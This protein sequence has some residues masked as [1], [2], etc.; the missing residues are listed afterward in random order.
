MKAK[1]LLLAAG[2]AFF[3]NTAYGQDISGDWQGTLEIAQR[4]LLVIVK[5]A[6]VPEGWSARLYSPEG[7]IDVGVSTR[8]DSVTLQGQDLRLTVTA[9]QATYTGKLS[10]DGNSIEGTWT[11]GPPTPLSRPLPLRRATPET[12]WKDPSPHTS[13]FVTVDKDVQLEVLDWGGT[14]RPLVFLTGEGNTAHVFDKFATLFT[15]THHVYGITR[16]GIGASS[17]PATGYASDRLGDDVLAVLASL[18]LTKPVLVAHSFG[19]S[20]LSSIGSRFPEKVA[21]LIYLEAGYEYAFYDKA[22]GNLI[23][24]LAELQRKLVQ[25]EPGKRPRDPRP[26]VKEILETHLPAFERALKEAQADLELIGAA[27]L[28]EPESAVEAA[29]EAGI[30]RYTVIPAPI[31]A[32]FASPHKAPTLP[33]NAPPARAARMAAMIARETSNTEAQVKA[34]ESGLPHARVVRLPG[35][36]HYVFRSNETEVVREMN[37]FLTALP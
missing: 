16:R 7:G 2:L 19:G 18:K 25:L 22:R 30:Q 21:G 15:A 35:A 11:Q 10:A 27:Q 37:S 9:A 32:I 26:L 24:D 23:L 28:A 13:Q 8:F 20:E 31:L 17:V 6:R 14:G 29:I 1:A 3:V 36:E 34:F 33:P 4:K 5:I 12:A